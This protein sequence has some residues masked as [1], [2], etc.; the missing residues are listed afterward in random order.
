MPFAICFFQKEPVF[1]YLMLSAKQ[2]NHWYHLFNVFGLT[3]S[4]V[5]YLG[6]K[7]GFK[8]TSV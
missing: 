7:L 8:A 3:L 5:S 4:F 1:P 2:R 6:G